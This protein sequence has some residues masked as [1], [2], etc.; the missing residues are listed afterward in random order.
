MSA[1]KRRYIILATDYTTKWVEARAT[2][3][4]D[5]STV[6]SFLFEEIMM[7]FGHPF[8]LVSDREAFPQ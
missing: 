6:A 1:G 3:K 8:E 2:I 7:R 5:A 4:N